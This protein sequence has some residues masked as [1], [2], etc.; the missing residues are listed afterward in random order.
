[1]NTQTTLGPF[2]HFIPALAE[3]ESRAANVPDPIQL[4]VVPPL[5]FVRLMMTNLALPAAQDGLTGRAFRFCNTP[6]NTP[7]SFLLPP[8]SSLPPNAQGCRRTHTGALQA[9]SDVAAD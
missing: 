1:M 5:P 2:I 6:C 9:A 4:Q 7:S 8:S 3:R